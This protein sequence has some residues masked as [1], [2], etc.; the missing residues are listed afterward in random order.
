M[1][2]PVLMHLKYIVCMLSLKFTGTAAQQTVQDTSEYSE[3]ARIGPPVVRYITNTHM[4]YSSYRK[5]VRFVLI[6]ENLPLGVF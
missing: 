4:D 3:C 5:L 2:Q 1:A 6:F